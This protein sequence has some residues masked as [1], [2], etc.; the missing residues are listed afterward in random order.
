VLV[1]LLS[2]LSP[3]CTRE[4]FARL[5][6]PGF[7]EGSKRLT[8]EIPAREEAGK[9]HSFSSKAQEIESNFGYR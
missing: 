8:S 4:H 6:G 7:D 2:I 5:R 3:G 9:P 1:G